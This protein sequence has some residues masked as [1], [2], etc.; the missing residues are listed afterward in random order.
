[1]LFRSSSSPGRAWAAAAFLAGA[2]A[3]APAIGNGF[4]FDDGV[5][6]EKNRLI[7]SF[8]TLPELVSRSE[9]A[10]AGYEVPAW[11]PLTDVTYAVNYAIS[12]ASAWSHHVTNALLHG[13]ATALIVLV[14]VRLGLAPIAAGAGALL[15]AIHPV[16]VEAVANVV[17]RKDVLATVFVA[18]MLLAHRWA[19]RRGGAALAVPVLA[20]AAAMLS[21]EVGTVGLALALLRDVLAADGCLR[22]EAAPWRRRALLLHATY[23]GAL[24]A[25]GVAY[26]AVTGGVVAPSVVDNP[27]A[28]QPTLVRLMTAVAVVGKGLALQAFPSGQS[29]D[30]SFDAIPLVRSPAD[31]RFLAAAAVLAAWLWAGLRLRRSAP[32]VLLALGWYVAALSPAANFLFPA[33]T[34]FGERL[35]YLP[36][37]GLALLAGSAF[38]TAR[39]R[40]PRPFRP[41]LDVAGL[42]VLALLAVATLRYAAA[43]SDELALF[44][45]ARESAPRSTRV[46][47][48]LAEVLLDRDRPAEAL[49]EIDVALDILPANAPAEVV[50][51]RALRALGRT[52]DEERSA[53]RAFAID[54][55]DPD[56]LYAVAR[57]ERDAGRLDAAADLWR[58]TLA[59][60]PS[61]A[62][63]LSDLAA[64]HLLRGEIPLAQ[65]LA[66]RAVAADERLASGWYNLALVHRARGDEPRARAALRRFV[67]VAG[68]EYRA[69]ATEVR[70][71]L[72]SAPP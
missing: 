61:Y 8:A 17:G 54:P 3:Y 26:L 48:K 5:V 2:A 34:I 4:A 25:Y 52:A 57:I 50:R 45:W 47:Q 51:A 56:A 29:P 31:L 43:W 69:E 49:A 9:W 19:V 72:A 63:A 32:I 23:A 39:S 10:G 35:L 53:R 21:K 71:A 59:F 30:W 55:T 40:L 15:F 41:G 27:L 20:Y 64:W 58:R 66:E 42:A 14:G 46:H 22:R 33:G 16:H 60:R 70:R 24:A 68:D 18:A 1:V 36:S 12:G 7:R 13:C 11:R 62:A 44:R 65:S 28:H 38:A 37:A 67:E 6:V